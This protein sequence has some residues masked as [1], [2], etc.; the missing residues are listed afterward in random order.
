MGAAMKRMEPLRVSAADVAREFEAVLDKVRRGAE[1]VV[2]QDRREIAIIA[3]SGRS[4][5]RAHAW[6]RA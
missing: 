6:G 1:I 4:D 5:P 2:E 3:P